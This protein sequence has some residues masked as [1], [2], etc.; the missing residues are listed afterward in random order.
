M[1]RNVQL[2]G[3]FLVSLVVSS[4]ALAG[5]DHVVIVSIDGG[6]PASI[7]QARMP[8][9][10]T[11][12]R[13]GAATFEAK[14]TLPSKTLPSHTSML[15]GVKPRVHQV[16]W[17][18]W[19]PLKGTVKVPTIFAQA[20]ARGHK[21]GMFATKSKFKH[22]NV[23]G[24]L[25]KFSLDAEDAIEV[26]TLSAAY[27]ASEKPRLLFVHMPDADAAG[28]DHGWESPEQLKALENVDRALG[29]LKQ[30]LETS[31][32]GKTFA[33][34][35]TADHGGSGTDHGSDSYDDQTIPWI[36]WGSG[37]RRNLRISGAVSTTATA[38][39]ALWLLGLPIPA[40]WP[41]APL[42]AAYE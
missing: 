10:E 16:T 22:L 31:L 21:T 24:S 23:Q 18:S 19:D 27:L 7:Q 6:K 39:T 38:S 26:A 3:L 33:L 36:T 12:I 8:V 15:T 17:N 2:L 30:A 32:P 5:V 41:S 42:T 13:E 29:I 11:L 35:I 25:D 40:S 34:I 1:T 9:L 37:V 28:H 20:R 4:A 14:T